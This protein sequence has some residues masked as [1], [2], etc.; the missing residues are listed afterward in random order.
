MDMR[1]LGKSGIAVSAMA[2]GCWSFGGGIYWGAQSQR[3]VDEV[4]ARALDQGVNLFDTAEM[5]NNG[6]SERALGQALGARRGQ[7]VV[8]SKVAPNHAYYHELIE[9]CDQSLSRLGTDY[10]DVYMLH[11]PINPISIKHFSSDPEKLEHPPTIE[12]AME[13]MMALQRQGKIRAI[14]ISN[15]G[16]R[17]MREALKTGARIDT[18]EM[19]YNIFSRAIEA[20]IQPFC[21]THGISIISSMALQQGVLTGHYKNANEVPMHQAHSRHYRDERGGGTSRHG[22]NG[23]EA[24]MFE[25][26]GQLRRIADDAGVTLPQIA[27]AWTMSRAGVASTLVGSRTVKELDE[28]ILAA[29]LVF[30]P[31]IIA[32]IDCASHPVLE[33][34][35]NNADYYESIENTR[36]Y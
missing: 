32:R 22:E 16:V 29:S 35:G 6:D 36:V 4:V 17:Q 34:L 33:K 20:E 10:L 26:L 1:I 3:E 12:E 30:A 24:E 18:N 23:A 2:V 13:A 14:G 21:V 15:F 8:C 27:I 5:Y 25:A 11:W 28:N 19:P 31:E 7:A 9:H